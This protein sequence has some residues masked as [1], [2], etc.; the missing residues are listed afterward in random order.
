MDDEAQKMEALKK[1]YAEIILNTAKEAAARV[2]ASERKALRYQHDL[3][4]TKDEALRVLCRLKQ[5]LDSKGFLLVM[6]G[7]TCVVWHCL[8]TSEAEITSLSQQRKIEELEAQLQEAED[9]ITDLRSEL[10]QVWSELERVNNNQVK[11]LDEQMTR[12]D[13]S[14]SYNPIPEPIILSSSATGHETIP[15]SGPKNIKANRGI[16]HKCCNEM[17]RSVSDLDKFFAPDSD[18]ASII[19]RP[20]EPEL[21]R[22][23]CTQRIRAFERN[24]LDDKPLPSGYV[25]NSICHEK[26]ELVIKANDKEEEKCGSPSFSDNSVEEVNGPSLE[27]TKRNAKVHTLRRRQTGFGKA[28]TSGRYRPSELMKSHQQTSV[29]SRCRVYSVNGK[30]SSQ[31]E[32]CILPSIKTKNVDMTG[33]SSGLEESSQHSSCYFMDRVKNIPKGKRKRKMKSKN[34]ITTSL[35]STDQPSSVLSRCRTFA[36]LLY[37]G[38]KSW[39]DQPITTENAAKMKSLPRL[40][41]G[42]ILMRNDVDPISGSAS[43]TVSMKGMNK[44]GTVQD[45]ADKDMELIDVPVLMTESDGIENSEAPNSELDLCSVDVSLMNSELKTVKV[46]LMNSELEHVNASL[47]KSE[48]NDASALLMSSELKDVR[49]SEQSNGS[50][51]RVDNSRLLKYTF[52]R[53]RKNSSRNPGEESTAKRRMEEKECVAQQPQTTDELS[54]DSRRLAQVARQLIS[55]SGKRWD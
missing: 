48:L 32:A 42:L 50:P 7:C 9:I 43:V 35:T 15:T 25:D 31:K 1:V 10:K 33:T 37:G 38:V 22:N 18:L 19:M 44:S 41:P 5:M 47:V 3:Q 13:A 29:P 53:K 14:F 12:E 23:G 20:K 6:F 2:M 45:A 52:Q 24:L 4:F 30:D 26:N 46:S 34:D 16:E 40:D 49:A 36:Y 11:P 28:K 8:K 21:L 54:R 55:L 51:S 27:E 39:E 17:K